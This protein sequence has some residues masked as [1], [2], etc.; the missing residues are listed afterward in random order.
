[1]KV[2]AARPEDEAGVMR[3]YMQFN[4]DR[5]KSGV[6]D[7]Q[8]KFIAGET[9]WAQTLTDKE[10]LTYVMRQ[11]DLLLGFITL[12]LPEFNPFHKVGKLAEVDLIVVDQ[13]LR[14]RRL[15]TLLYTTAEQQLRIIGVTHVL[16]NV[17]VGNVPAM[18]FWTKMG[19][20]KVAN[21]DYKRSDGADEKTIYM[22]KKIK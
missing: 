12:R 4:E 11:K 6:G 9:P 22:M 20:K 7:A 2:Q 10:C 19:F 5:I 1:M 18:L 15:G 3:L 13:K 8:Y 17:K 16:I 14:R 21:T